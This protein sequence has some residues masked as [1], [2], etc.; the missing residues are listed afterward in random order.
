MDLVPRASLP[1][2]HCRE[3][4]VSATSGRLQ[5]SNGYYF[6]GRFHTGNDYAGNISGFILDDHVPRMTGDT[7][8]GHRSRAQAIGYLQA[9]IA[10]VEDEAES[11]M[12][13]IPVADLDQLMGIDHLVR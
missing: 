8:Y 9:L 3:L 13:H 7:A 12:L 5:G 6:F 1:K 4:R 2:L 11:L 10:V